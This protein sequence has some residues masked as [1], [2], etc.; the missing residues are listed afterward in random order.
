MA[1]S[2]FYNFLFKD[3]GVPNNYT[4]SVWTKVKNM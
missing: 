2:T 4:I 3:Y 1:N